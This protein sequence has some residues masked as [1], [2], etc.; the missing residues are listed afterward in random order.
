VNKHH[1]N[2]NLIAQQLLNSELKESSSVKAIQNLQDFYNDKD[3]I[4][5][6]PPETGLEKGKIYTKNGLA[7]SPVQAALCIKEVIRTHALIKGVNQAIEELLETVSERPLHVLYAGC[8]PYAPLV[9]PL[10]SIFS[11]DQVRFTL[12]DVNEVSLSS[13]KKCIELLGYEK[14]VNAYLCE[15]ACASDFSDMGN[16]DIVLSETM[17]YALRK[18]PQVALFRNIYR[19]FPKAVYLPESITISASHHYPT[20]IEPVAHTTHYDLRNWQTSK[21]NKIFE[22][23]IVTMSQWQN[24]EGENLPADSVVMPTNFSQH[25]DLKLETTIQVYKDIIL[26]ENDSSLN[27]AQKIKFKEIPKA[28]DEVSFHYQLGTDPCIVATYATQKIHCI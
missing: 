16:V 10:I 7:V 26:G 20:Y 8:G 3:N 1:Q 9:L 17:N 21:L 23:N 13:S 18:E 4:E 11:D 12:L 28:G 15:D 2:L 14:S 25:C 19:K 27:I 22:L 24:I 5:S 6:F